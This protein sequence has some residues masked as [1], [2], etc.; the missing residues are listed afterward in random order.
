MKE[1]ELTQRPLPSDDNPLNAEFF[2][3]CARGE[4]RFQRC[5][6]CG[7]WRHPPR[8]R[9]PGCGSE[10]WSWSRSSG[11]GRIF[12]WTLVHRAMHPSFQEVPYAVVVV[13][14]TEGPRVVSRLRNLPHSKIRLDLPVEVEIEKVSDTVGLGY[15]RPYSSSSPS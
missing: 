1:S 3:H 10:D 7:R 15:F 13:E 5:D 11:R 14:M 4:L 9:C 6:D 2:A 12:S 8:Y